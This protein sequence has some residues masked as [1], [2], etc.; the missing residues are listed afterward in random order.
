MCRAVQQANFHEVDLRVLLVQPFTW[1]EFCPI[2]CSWVHH[3]QLI[4]S[5]TWLI[6]RQVKSAFPNLLGVKPDARMSWNAQSY[7]LRRAQ[8]MRT[9]CTCVPFRSVHLC[10]SRWQSALRPDLESIRTIRHL[11]ER[12]PINDCERYRGCSGKWYWPSV[13]YFGAANNIMLVSTS[14]ALKIDTGIVRESV[15]LMKA[16]SEDC[17][18]TL[19]S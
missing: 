4:P 5:L 13:E 17:A 2:R 10:A 1:K 9:C 12:S 15:S 19:T 14:K 11:M 8:E 16:T 7:N 18:W 6:Y 3:T